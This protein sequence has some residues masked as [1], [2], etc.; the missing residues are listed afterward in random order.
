[1]MKRRIAVGA[2]LA[3]ALAAGCVKRHPKERAAEQ[4]SETARPAP[5]GIP[6]RA[7]RPRVPAS[8]QGLLAPGAIGELQ[9]ALAERG[10]LA[11]HRRGELD[12]PTTRAVRKFQSDEHLAA[13]GVP[14]HETL[15]RLGVDPDKAYR[16]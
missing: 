14:D 7:G 5:R 4:P 8:P 1:M 12:E 16:K 2:L 6:P 10:Y 15:Q 9:R 11:A 3:G 13:T